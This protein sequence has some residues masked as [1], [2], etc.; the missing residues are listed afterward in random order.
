MNTIEDVRIVKHEN[1]FY[2]VAID[3]SELYDYKRIRDVKSFKDSI[4]T[5]VKVDEGKPKSRLIVTSEEMKDLYT[6]ASKR[7]PKENKSKI[8]TII[9]KLEELNEIEDMANQVQR[10]VI[11]DD[12]NRIIGELKEELNSKDKLIRH[13]E[14][15]TIYYKDLSEESDEQVLNLALENGSLKG[16]ECPICKLKRRIQSWR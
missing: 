2:A 7:V 11:I 12:K 5:P 10:D 15:E 6:I 4:V 14:I 9:E 16:K 3:L 8:L 1:K 13:L